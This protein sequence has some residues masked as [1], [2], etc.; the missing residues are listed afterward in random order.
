MLRER[1]GRRGVD[2]ESAQGQFSAAAHLNG[3]RVGYAFLSTERL[4][5]ALSALREELEPWLGASRAS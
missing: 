1:L 3:F 4:R 5:L 2:I